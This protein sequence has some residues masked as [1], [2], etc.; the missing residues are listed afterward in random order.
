MFFYPL[1]M[2]ILVLRTPR[3]QH[4]L[5]HGQSMLSKLCIS[6][7][8]FKILSFLLLLELIITEHVLPTF[9]D[10]FAKEKT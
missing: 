8:F 1:V 4:G 5:Q 3:K 10:M 2:N 6:H 9:L 7:D